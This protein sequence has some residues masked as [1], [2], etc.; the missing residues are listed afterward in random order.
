MREGGGENGW[1]ELADAREKRGDIEQLP[2]TAPEPL[3]LSASYL[4][5]LPI[6]LSL[7]N[8]VRLLADASIRGTY[9]SSDP[10]FQSVAQLDN[11]KIRLRIKLFSRSNASHTNELPPPADPYSFCFPLNL[12]HS[13]SSPPQATVHTIDPEASGKSEAIRISSVQQWPLRIFSSALNY[14]VVRASSYA[15]I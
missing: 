6:S 2:R 5:E 4:P 12:S 9:L 8:V 15:T 13:D 14:R 3:L 7:D 1:S 11:H 10:E